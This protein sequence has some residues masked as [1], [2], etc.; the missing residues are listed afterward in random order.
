MTKYF[1][2]FQGSCKKCKRT[3]DVVSRSDQEGL[4]L[5]RHFPKDVMKFCDNSLVEF[6]R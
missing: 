5:S 3:I 4:V 2:Q 6:V 1:I